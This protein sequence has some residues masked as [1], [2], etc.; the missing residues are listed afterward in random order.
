MI[1]FGPVPFRVRYINM[2][3]C[4]MCRWSICPNGMRYDFCRYD[5]MPLEQSDEDDFEFTCKHF[6][7][8]SH[9]SV[10][11]YIFNYFKPNSKVC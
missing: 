2:S 8:Y 3:Y 1:R 5:G 11:S 7:T 4:M 6:E 10:Q 9:D